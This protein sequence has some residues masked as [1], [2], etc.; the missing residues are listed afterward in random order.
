MIKHANFE[1]VAALCT[2]A[3]E[4][5]A[6]KISMRGFEGLAEDTHGRLQR[7][8]KSC[9]LL[10]CLTL[11]L[12]ATS[13][14]TAT[15]SA[16]AGLPDPLP[17][18]SEPGVSLKSL[19]AAV[20]MSNFDDKVFLD[21]LQLLSSKKIEETKAC[22]RQLEE[23]AAGQWLATDWHLAEDGTQAGGDSLKSVLDVF[24]STAGKVKVKALHGACED[25]G[26]G[27]AVS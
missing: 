22:V 11:F 1:A 16:L 25:F 5:S 2:L 20:C 6:L 19:N 13:A 21:A 12:N 24:E 23:S 8:T 17:S 7:D 14:M 15:T 18:D 3:K 9:K 10:E 26:Q 27:G 4:S